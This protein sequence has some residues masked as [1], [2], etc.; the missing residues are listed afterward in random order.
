M[1]WNK[2]IFLTG[3]V[4]DTILML[5]VCLNI[6]YFVETENLLLKVP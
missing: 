1:I 2:T 4:V 6:A 3:M 5:R